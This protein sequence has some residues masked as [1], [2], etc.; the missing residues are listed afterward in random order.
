MPS[1]TLRVSTDVRDRINQITQE[2][3]STVNQ[4]ITRA[5][6]RLEEALF[7]EEFAT[8]ARLV[9]SDSATVAAEADE[10]AAWE[11]TLRDGLDA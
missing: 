11:R 2:T 4:V 9:A 7:W 1:T 5:L 8:A 3:H 6:D 10:R